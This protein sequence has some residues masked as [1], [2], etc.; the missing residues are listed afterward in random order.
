MPLLGRDRPSGRPPCKKSIQA[1]GTGRWLLGE[2]VPCLQGGKFKHQCMLK[3][4][5]H[6]TKLQDVT[7]IDLCWCP[8]RF[9]G[10][11][12]SFVSNDPLL[13]ITLAYMY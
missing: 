13:C 11:I 3:G 10:N 5:V 12:P 4:E 1:C 6:S 7:H 9:D 2:Q 8:L